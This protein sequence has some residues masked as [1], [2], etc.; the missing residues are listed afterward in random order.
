MIRLPGPGPKCLL[1]LFLCCAL[2][3]AAFGHSYAECF[4]RRVQICKDFFPPSW[5]TDCVVGATG[6]CASHTHGRGFT[7]VEFPFGSRTFPEVDAM[8]KDDSI[9]AEH[10]AMARE[11]L[12]AHRLAEEARTREF[13]AILRAMTLTDGGGMPCEQPEAPKK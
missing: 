10:K 1:G 2:P 4:A 3:G 7:P 9:S 5:Y 6:S 12:E 11:A 8:L 13:N